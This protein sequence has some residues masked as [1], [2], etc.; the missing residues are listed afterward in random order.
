MVFLLVA[1]VMTEIL[2]L[3]TDALL[4]AQIKLASP[5]AMEQENL[6]VSSY[7]GSIL[8]S[9]RDGKSSSLHLRL[10]VA[11]FALNVNTM[12]GIQFLGA[13]VAF[14]LSSIY[15]K[16]KSAKKEAK[17]EAEASEQQKDGKS[18]LYF[19]GDGIGFGL[20]DSNYREDGEGDSMEIDEGAREMLQ[21]G[22]EGQA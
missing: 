2:Y 12:V 13:I 20:L 14:I 8:R 11:R 17:A 6:S 7:S 1:H 4:I 18:N 22:K 9:I 21:E 5:A 16:R 15:L 3:E 19:Y 10:E